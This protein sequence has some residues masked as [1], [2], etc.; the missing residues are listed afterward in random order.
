[1]SKIE[2]L[3]KTKSLSE[4]SMLLGFSPKAVSYIIYKIPPNKKYIQFTIPKKNGGKRLINAPTDKLKLLQRRLADLLNDCYDEIYN[5]EDFKKS[6][7]HGFR[8][9]HSIITNAKKHKNKRYVFNLDLLNFFPAINF[10][11]VQ[12][13]FIKNN[14]FNLDQKVATVIA[15][16]ASYNNELPQG[17][18]CSPII[19]NL[20]GHLIDVRMVKLAKETKCT[21]SRY[22][23]DLT[24]STNLKCFPQ[25]IANFNNDEWFVSEHL[26][27]EIKKIGFSI[28]Y[29]KT[30]MQYKT[31]R[32]IATGLIVNKKVNVKREYYKNARSMCYELF[33]SDN[34]FI[35]A[36]KNTLPLSPEGSETNGKTKGT[37]NQLEGIL[38]F[39]YQVKEHYIKIESTQKNIPT[40]ITELYRKFLFYKHFFAIE[41]PLIICEGKTDCIYLKCALRQLASEYVEFIQKNDNGFEFKIGFFNKLSKNIGEVFHMAPGSSGL[42]SL[43]NMFENNMKTFNGQGKR[44]PVIIIADND[45]GASKIKSRIKEQLRITT[46]TLDKPFYKFISNLYIMFVSEES[47]KA[48]EDLFD[49]EILEIKVDGKVFNRNNEIDNKKEYGK[50]VFAEKVI[51]LKEKEINFTEF[52]SVFNTLKLIINNHE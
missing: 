19:S 4:L 26:M 39:I 45:E 10:G 38:S 1:M 44:H 2:K 16:I 18:P 21:Y 33:K 9:K 29:K 22:A 48:I 15:Q 40:S 32:Q 17:S 12:G 6:L 7:S 52:R 3:K 14:Y 27:H 35:R 46:T 25:K 28:N 49:K 24:F 34:F 42:L 31:S 36:Q 8:N 37:L 13:F 41:K 47:N 5:K 11:R 20:I 43:M 51:K 50:I 30:S 23:D